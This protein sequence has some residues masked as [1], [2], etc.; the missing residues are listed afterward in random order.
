M[1]VTVDMREKCLLLY[2]LPEWEAV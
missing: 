2:P 1:V